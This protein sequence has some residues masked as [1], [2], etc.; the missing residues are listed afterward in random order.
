MSR[1]QADLNCFKNILELTSTDI[2]HKN[3]FFVHK[4]FKGKVLNPN[5][6]YILNMA[7]SEFPLKTNYELTRILHVYNG[8]N[9]VEIIKIFGMSRV[10]KSWQVSD[11]VIKQTNISKSAPPHGFRIVKGSAYC[12]LSREF[13]AYVMASKQAKDLLAW[14][15]DTYSP[16]EWFWATMQYNTQFKPPGGFK[17]I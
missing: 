17:G 13:I 7:S 14:G 15:Q 5:W 2:N 12:V 9:E 4:N 11:G 6:K 1:L 8:T 16:D 3:H 10:D